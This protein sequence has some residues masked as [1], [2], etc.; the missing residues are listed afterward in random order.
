M[1]GRSAILVLAAAVV[2]ATPTAATARP[3]SGPGP[4]VPDPLISFPA[5]YSYTTLVVSC[6]T[7][8]RS[9]ESGLTFPYP[10]DPDAT[11]LFQGPRGETWLLTNAELTQ[12]RPGDFQGD[13][14]KCAVEEQTPGDGDSDGSGSVQRIVLDRDGT[15][16]RG[17]DV[18]TTGLHNLC[19]AAKTPWN[20]YL[21]NE[22][23]PFVVDPQQR[24]G[25]VWEVDPATGAA[26]RLTGMGRFSHEQEALAGGD[27]YLTDDRGDARFIYR[28][29]PRRPRDLT[30]GN[31][32]GLAFDKTTGTGTW[33]GPL[34]PHNPDGDM[35]TRGY[36]PAVSGFVKA[37]GMI[38]TGGPANRGGDAVYFTES[39][40]GGDPGRVWRLDHL[41]DRGVRGAVVVEGDFDR[42]ARPDNLRFNAA[43]DL[44]IMEDHSSSDFGRGDTGDVNQAWVLPRHRTGAANLV[45]LAETPHE[46]TGAWFSS[47]GRL[48]YLSVQA[49][50]RGTSHVIAVRAPSNWNRPIRR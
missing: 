33:V 30:T 2:V 38:A 20:T 27:W 23:F 39:G 22:E 16:V 12:A 13:A 49:E 31:L 19:A 17:V 28:F 14:G 34:D 37:E 25:W 6:Q 9:T 11:V 3:G 29:D 18:V 21:T 24:S 1:A 5:G 47:D 42:L 45:L 10:D 46:P 4:L 43:G 44:F 40:A 26:T 7:P 8:A 32:Y 41:G 35:R 15:T 50:A 48:L 36:D